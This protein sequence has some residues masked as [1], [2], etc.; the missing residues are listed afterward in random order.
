MQTGGRYKI[1]FVLDRKIGRKV[2]VSSG[3]YHYSERESSTPASINH[4]V[5]SMEEMYCI[6]HISTA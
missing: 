2:I 1:M 4:M 6:V 3:Q 5:I